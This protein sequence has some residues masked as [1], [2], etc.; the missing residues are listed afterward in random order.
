M[1]FFYSKDNNR[2]KKDE[3]YLEEIEKCLRD[4]TVHVRNVWWE[5]AEN[6]I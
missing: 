5:P 3:F 1:S 4:E 6:S 2:I